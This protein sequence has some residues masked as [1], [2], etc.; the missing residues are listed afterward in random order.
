MRYVMKQKLFSWADDYTIKN[1]N[2]EDAF[3]V[4]G[5]AF[6]LGSQL[7]F[8]DL[9]G[10]QLAY[11]KQKLLS[12]GPTYEIYKDDR[13]YA[14]IRKELFTFFKCSFVVH[15]EEQDDLD[16]EGNLTDHEYV[17]TRKGERVA[18]ISKQWFE[19]ADTYGVD[20]AEGEDAILI[21]A[22]TVAIDLSCHGDSK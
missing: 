16:A 5:K 21:L 8:Q 14:T 15:V 19:W 4:D 11:I 1:Q 13:H 12:W 9:R 6:S 22:S 7:S 2:G 10:N 3:F 17:I 18:A 20:I